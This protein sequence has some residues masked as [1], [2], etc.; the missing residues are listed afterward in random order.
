MREISSS[1]NSL[2][3]QLRLL[4]SKKHRDR[5][6]RYLVEG[7]TT[8]MEALTGAALIECVITCDAE[9]AAAELA[10]KRGLDVIVVPRPILLTL[11]DTKT[12]PNVLASILKESPAA[13]PQSGIVIICDAV[14][15]PKNL[16]TIIRTA[17]ACGAAGVILGAD[18]ADPYGPKCQRGAMGSMFHLP[19]VE[20]DA[21]DYLRNFRR[22]GGKVVAG[23]LEGTSALGAVRADTAIVVGNEARGVSAEVRELVDIAYRI[24]IYGRADSLNAAVAAGIMMYDIVRRLRG[25]VRS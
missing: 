12:P 25:D 17:D 14:Q 4:R 2:I 9:N 5:Q 11:S 3:R 8:V 23:I 1:S 6:N 18:C 13:E 15:D 20:R 24:P 16:G 22:R 21:P 19:V 7:E 10:E